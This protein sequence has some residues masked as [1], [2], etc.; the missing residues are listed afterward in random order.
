M[1]N[2]Y[3]RHYSCLW[4]LE[5]DVRPASGMQ[6][7]DASTPITTL[8]FKRVTQ[9][10]QKLIFQYEDLFLFSIFLIY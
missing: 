1:S 7:V 8:Q 9:L 10:T 6:P 2:V 4:W 3:G 5:A